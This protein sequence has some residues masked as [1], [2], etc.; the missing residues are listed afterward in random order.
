MPP[1]TKK[2]LIYRGIERYRNGHFSSHWLFTQINPIFFPKFPPIPHN[3]ECSPNIHTCIGV[4][5]SGGYWSECRENRLQGNLIKEW[6][7]SM[8]WDIE[9]LKWFYAGSQTRSRVYEGCPLAWWY[10][11]FL[12]KPS[13]CHPF[14]SRCTKP[15][16]LAL[17]AVCA[18]LD[19][20]MFGCFVQCTI[21]NKLC[22]LNVSLNLFSVSH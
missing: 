20:L 21:V 16:L 14:F 4:K 3:F 13:L 18:I 12:G 6:D 22:L 7:C 17:L 11:V 10:K 19:L 8:S 5:E 9:Q 2:Y 1:K 15:P